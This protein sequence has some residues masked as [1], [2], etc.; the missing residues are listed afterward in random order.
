MAE[1][2]VKLGGGE[3]VLEGSQWV[4]RGDVPRETLELANEMAG[5]G[6]WWHPASGYPG[7]GLASAVA[8]EI[9]GE[10]ILPPLPPSKPG[11]VH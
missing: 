6:D 8:K 10:A 2:K 7:Y 11:I 5:D 1:I 3:L 4:A 9:G